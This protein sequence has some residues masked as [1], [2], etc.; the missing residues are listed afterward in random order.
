M[1]QDWAVWFGREPDEK[2]A[3]SPLRMIWFSVDKEHPVFFASSLLGL[4][5]SIL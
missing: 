5:F 4:I 3:P 1:P 2:Y